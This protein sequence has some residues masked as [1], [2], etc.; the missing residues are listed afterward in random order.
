[1]IKCRG[2]LTGRRQSPF[3]I[4]TLQV[5]LC[6]G[7]VCALSLTPEDRLHTQAGSTTMQ[8]RGGK[9]TKREMVIESPQQYKSVAEIEAEVEAGSQVAV[10]SV[11]TMPSFT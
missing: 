4:R 10:V 6:H 3:N 2:N 5:T 7:S 1:M 8:G 11:C 9:S